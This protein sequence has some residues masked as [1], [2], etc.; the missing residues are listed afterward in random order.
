MQA[1]TIAANRS[2]RPRNVPLDQL[3]RTLAHSW[4]ARFIERSARERA[5]ND[6]HAAGCRCPECDPDY[7]D[8]RRLEREA[9]EEIEQE[10]RA[11]GGEL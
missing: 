8:P 5:A 1:P 2:R 3:A 4:G 7:N 10:Q 6:E 9:C 11:N